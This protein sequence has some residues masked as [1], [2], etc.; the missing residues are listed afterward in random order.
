MKIFTR[1]NKFIV[2]CLIFTLI[3]ACYT[4]AMASE[5][6][7][8]NQTI[9][10]INEPYVYPVQPGDELWKQFTTHDEKIA[11]CQIP[12]DIL[13]KMTKDA[14]TETVLN[15]PLMIDMLAMPNRM[16]GYENIYNNFNG[17][18]ELASRSNVS[19]DMIQVKD[20]LSVNKTFKATEN[21]NDILKP[22]YLDAIIDGINASNYFNSNTLNSV[23]GEITP[24]YSS[25]WV[26]TKM[27][28]A[29]YAMY[30]K[31]WSDAMNTAF[32]LDAG[33]KQFRLT[34]PN[35]VLAYTWEMAVILRQLQLQVVKFFMIQY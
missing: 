4:T 27:G 22:V 33:T 6:K 9:Y 10:T 15:Y 35:A 12:E 29:V 20:E 2:I 25:S 18:R 26:Y 8:E 3:M 16:T 21:N 5:I 1:K 23:S 14:L 13:S 7:Y 30:N 32:M 11:A 28:T 17:L 34:Y 24:Y 31:T 19:N